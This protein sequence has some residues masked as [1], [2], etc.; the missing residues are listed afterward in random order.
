V[1]WLKSEKLILVLPTDS[2]EDP[3]KAIARKLDGCLQTGRSRCFSSFPPG[4]GPFVGMRPAFWVHDFSL[5][6][7]IGLAIPVGAWK[8]A[9][10]RGGEASHLNLRRVSSVSD[11]F[12]SP[13]SDG[14]I[15][16]GMK[17]NKDQD[18]G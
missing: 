4:V 8:I 6:G 11:G 14:S 15:A 18:K 5:P 2:L 16:I 3:Q 17:E 7:T 9:I 10:H 13:E 1:S 12:I